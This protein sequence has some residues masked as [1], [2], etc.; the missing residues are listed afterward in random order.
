[1]WPI[2]SAV[3]F[4]LSKRGF[5]QNWFFDEQVVDVDEMMVVKPQQQVQVKVRSLL[6]RPKRSVQK[7]LLVFKLFASSRLLLLCSSRWFSSTGVLKSS[8]IGSFL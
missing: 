5:F 4:K 8:C 6:F 2:T 3:V 7:T 1:M